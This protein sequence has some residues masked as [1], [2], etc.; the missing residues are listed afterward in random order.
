MRPDR[1][2]RHDHAD[3]DLAA[4]AARLVL[5]GAAADVAAALRQVGG[6]PRLRGLVRRHLEVL[7]QVEHGGDATAAR[8]AAVLDVAIAVM[9][10]IEDL[11]ER[12]ADLGIPFAGVRLSGHAATGRPGPG[13]RVH[14]RYHGDRDA[15]D[16]ARELEDLGATDVRVGAIVTRWGR[17][18][19]IEA[20]LD[21]V[22]LRI[23][24]CPVGQVPLTAA[25][26]V[27]GGPVPLA[28]LQAAHRLR[29]AC[30]RDLEG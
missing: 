30:D 22:E 19:S 21:G 6:E 24:R 1:H 18:S 29:A 9:E 27:T 23:R 11:E 3:D 7:E 8:R 2:H 14:L 10:A 28:D 16:V 25:N 12:T 26:L 15:D 13:E 5:D 20:V 4:R 17:L